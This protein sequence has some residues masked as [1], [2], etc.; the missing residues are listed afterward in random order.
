MTT[1]SKNVMQHRKVLKETG[2][3]FAKSIPLVGPHIEA[4]EKMFTLFSE[5]NATTCRERFNRYIMGIGEICDD[6]VDISREHFSALVKK[7]VLDD[8][9]KKT[10]Y[11]IR[12]TVSLARSSLND[13]EKLFFIHILSGLTCF[14][15]EYARKL[16]ITT[17]SPIKGYK[18][19]VLA[20][21]SLTSQKSGMA[22]RSLN[23]LITSGL[24]YE[25]RAGEIQAN[26]MFKL[27]DELER[28]LGFIF[29]KDDLEPEALSIEPKEEYDVI[30]IESSEIYSGAYPNS[31]YRSLKAAGIKVCIEKNEDCITTKLA[32]YFISVKT[33]SGLNGEGEWIEFGQIYV[34]KRLD[35]S[36][37]RFYENEHSETVSISNFKPKDNDQTY[38]ASLLNIALNN[39]AAFVLNRLSPT[40]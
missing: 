24:V 31:I 18:S 20:Q 30:I 5:I 38:D 10:E 4:A 1:L 21:V 37:K 25:D 7:L 23:K 12:L 14:D 39:I 36:S 35:S 22:L 6:E 13:D 32:R 29:H 15:I 40:T 8:E 28:L 11:Y 34:L 33:G 27:T 2:L 16:Y 3:A 17:S 9:D 19:T 26:P